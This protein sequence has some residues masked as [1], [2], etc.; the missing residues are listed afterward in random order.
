MI[1]TRSNTSPVPSAF[2]AQTGCVNGWK[3]R[4]QQSKGVLA[5]G[6]GASALLNDGVRIKHNLCKLV[7]PTPC[8]L[9]M[10]NGTHGGQHVQHE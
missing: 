4:A 9:R 1:L 2:L 6:W 8:S 5:P 3:D 10:K 7:R